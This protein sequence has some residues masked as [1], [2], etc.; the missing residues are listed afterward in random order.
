MK[1]TGTSEDETAL[2]FGLTNPPMIASWKKA[3]LEGGVE[4]LS[5]EICRL[6]LFCQ[7]VCLLKRGFQNRSLKG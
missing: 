4:V 6:V 3:F 5:I 2:H 7:R 1:R